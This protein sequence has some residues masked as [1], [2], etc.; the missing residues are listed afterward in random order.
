MRNTRQKILE[1][2]QDLFYR[3]GYQG[4]VVNQI[5]SDAGVS[6][7][8]FYNHFDSKEGLCVATLQRKRELDLSYF[9]ERTRQASTPFGRFMA[10]V[11][12][13]KERMVGTNY[14]GCGF[15]NMLTEITDPKSPILVEIR[16]FN[17]SFRALLRDVT[18]DLVN[19]GGKYAELDVD[20]VADS[21]YLIF[22]GAIMF[23][24][25]YQETWPLD[26]A[27]TQVERLVQ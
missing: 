11:H 19:S 25:E 4:T 16:H 8:T 9:R 22:G 24:Q 6:K 1:T 7:P 15:F 12:V 14:R 26:L 20:R 5:I 27:A 13:L 21:Y 17:D 10:P 3:Q 2:A 18:M 23:S